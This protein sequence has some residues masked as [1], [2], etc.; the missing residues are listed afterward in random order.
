MEA[1]RSLLL[2]AGAGHGVP[3]AALLRAVQT[4]LDLQH[5]QLGEGAMAEACLLAATH[6]G[7]LQVRSDVK[8]SAAQWLAKAV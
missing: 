2:V 7:L 4:L 3:P 5:R 1:A 6:L 8:R